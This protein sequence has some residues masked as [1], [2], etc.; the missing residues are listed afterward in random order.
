MHNNKEI[1]GFDIGDMV[2]MNS[3]PSED[4]INW[5]GNDNPKGLIELNKPY[6][7]SNIDVHTWHTKINLEGI[8]GQFNS[9]SFN[10]A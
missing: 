8:K 7:V 10:L 2:I 3:Y 9:I 6:K 1:C 5:G 4:Q